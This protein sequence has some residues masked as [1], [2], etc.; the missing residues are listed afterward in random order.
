M[1]LWSHRVAC[2]PFV[3][4]RRLK[5]LFVDLQSVSHYIFSYASGRGV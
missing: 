2:G 4:Q 1:L 5:T 3:R